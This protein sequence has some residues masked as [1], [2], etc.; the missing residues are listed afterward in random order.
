MNSVVTNMANPKP[1][2]ISNIDGETPN[3]YFGR[4]TFFPFLDGIFNTL[5]KICNEVK[6]FSAL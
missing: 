3:D 5:G 4:S 1:N 2:K 6:L